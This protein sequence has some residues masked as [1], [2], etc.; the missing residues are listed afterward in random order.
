MS[1]VATGNPAITVVALH[2]NGGGAFR[3]ARVK[4]FV[5]DGVDFLAVTL[6]GFADVPRDPSLETLADYADRLR[7]VIPGGP[8]P[9]VMLGHG[10][11]GSIALEFVQRHPDAI[12][13]LILHAPVGARLDSRRFPKLMKPRPVREL[14]KLVISSKPTRPLMKRLLF[15]GPVPDWYADRFF[16]EYRSCTA[17]SQMFDLITAAWFRNL[18][19]VRLPA[20]LLWGAN[21]RILDVEQARDYESLLPDA[22]KRLVPGWD[23]FPMIEQP[24]EYAR[25]ISALA[26]K[27]V[28]R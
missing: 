15:D 10:I 13:G 8:H 5:P 20:V 18:E 27:L 14:V 1:A 9:V 21:E 28:S 16:E 2:G 12:D 26:R 24:E 4:P 7:A 11:G 3:F 17:F 25:E 23:H 19:P 6:P 22:E